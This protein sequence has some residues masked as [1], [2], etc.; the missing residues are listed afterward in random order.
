MHEAICASQI[1]GA[2]TLQLIENLD[3]TKS[4][5]AHP[6]CAT[7]HGVRLHLLDSAVVIAVLFACIL[8]VIGDLCNSC[9]A[10]TTGVDEHAMANICCDHDS[11]NRFHGHDV[12]TNRCSC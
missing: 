4:Q 5:Q 7:W 12:D 9:V 1:L 2:N 11:D 8:V 6:S 10:L 3:G